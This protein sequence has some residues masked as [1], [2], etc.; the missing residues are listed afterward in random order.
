MRNT[1]RATGAFFLLF[2]I[3]LYVAVIPAHVSDMEGG[4]ILPSTIPNATA[5][6]LALCGAVL[7]LK[8]T[9]QSIHSAKHFFRAGLYFTLLALGLWAM[10]Y[11]GFIYAGPAIA[12][13]LMLLMGE[14]RPFW[15]VASVI[16]LPATI[17]FLVT[18][19]L[20]RSLP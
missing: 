3:V 10:S 7:V 8:P 11:V 17:W 15:I 6:I 14:L 13:V 20:E 12:L 1:D 19:V 9:V 18:V 16:I 4:W 2:G 5:A